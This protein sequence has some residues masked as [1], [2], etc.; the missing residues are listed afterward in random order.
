MDVPSNHGPC[1]MFSVVSPLTCCLESISNLLSTFIA[2]TW[3]V[4]LSLTT[5]TCMGREGGGR[6]MEREEPE[7][8]GEGV[9][10]DN[11]SREGREMRD[12]ERFES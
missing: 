10:G 11:R 8:R 12:R 5:C 7:Q 6:E 2:Y 4:P 9:G 3:S 1:T